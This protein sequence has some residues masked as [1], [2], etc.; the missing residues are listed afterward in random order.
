MF[1]IQVLV[2]TNSLNVN[3]LYSYFYEEEIEKFKRVKVSFNHQNLIALVIE[4]F[5]VS[6]LK[7]YESEVGYKLNKII[8]VVDD[9]P[10]INQRQFELAKY[11]SK[12]TICPFITCLNTMLPKALR[13]NK[14]IHKPVYEEY[15]LKNNDTE[16]KFTKKQKDIFDKYYDLMLTKDARKLSVSIFNKLLENKVIQ[17][18][19]KEKEY[20][21]IH[22]INLK[23]FK[24]LTKEQNEVYEG[25]LNSNKSINLLFGVTGAGKTEVYLHLS[26][27][28]LEEGKQVLILV[29]EISLTPQMINRVKE[30]FEDVI[31]YHSALTDQERYEQ[32]KRVI[33]K[34]VR[35]VV[36]TRSSIFLP[37][38]NLGLIIIDEEHDTSYKQDN[39]PCYSVKNVAIRLAHD[40]KGK[41]LLA[42]ATPSLDSYTRALKGEYGLL[43]LNKR[44]NNM[45][46]DIE[47]INLANECKNK[48]SY[49]I[50][51]RLKE[52]IGN[53]LS[54][55]EQIIILLNRRGYSP[56][57]KCLDCAS[58]LMCGSCDRAL[59]YHCD[60]NL[61]KCHECGKEYK[62]PRY[63]PKCG[64]NNLAFYG[65]GTQKVEEEL[66]R[67]FP[68]ARI[69]RM[70]RDNTN[71][72]GA[73]EKI[74]EDF[75]NYQYDILIG[76]Q[77]IAKGLDFPKVTLVGILN[78]DA[79]LMHQDF[80][81]TNLTFNLLMQASGRSGRS[82]NNGLVII[83][84]F[85][86]E[87]YVLK[88]ILKQD[89]EYYYNIEMNYRYKLNYPP[90]SHI[91]ELIIYDINQEKVDRSISYLQSKIE[92]LTS[93]KY[94]PVKLG[95][96]KDIYR[97]RIMLMD[98]NGIYLLDTMWNIID[99]YLKTN[100]AKIKI[101][102]DPLYLE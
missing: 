3:K 37:F 77:M 49:I 88:A 84:A 95:K 19:Q 24:T 93:K 5:N 40:F 43:R 4:S 14:N 55:K 58:T 90:Y 53:K 2:G 33:Q 96:I 38:D 34:E 36:G 98:K 97:T 63:C 75:G 50:S 27:K 72:K 31:F 35:I 61:L 100:N 26:K 85:N 91:L 32:Y 99:E 56:V 23:A 46:P 65:F 71:K 20:K 79:G 44:I 51:K 1:I 7:E 94:R 60:V 80:N 25:L 9:L 101:E 76:T 64:S 66:K 67:L 8:E 12:T 17:I 15:L 70:D 28:Y 57:V 74:L 78:A 69:V 39:S 73:H 81:A 16:Y 52:E 22:N 54:R 45:L 47:I 83:Q 92:H 59:N 87:H 89:Y 18:I 41:V 86:P 102:M 21:G 30:R 13:T 11:L 82:I 68:F 10:I 29:P 62:V 6:S 42:S 48:G